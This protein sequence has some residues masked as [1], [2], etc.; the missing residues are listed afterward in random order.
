MIEKAMKAEQDYLAAR[1]AGQEVILD[2]SSFG[3][4]N[5]EDYFEAKKEYQMRHCGLVLHTPPMDTVIAEFIE[6]VKNQEPSVWIP[7]ADSVFVWHGDDVIDEDLCARLGV[8]IHQMPNFIGGNIISGPQ[9]FSMTV[10]MPSSIDITTEYMLE[11]MKTIMDKYIDGIVIDGNDFMLNG[12]KV[13][14]VMNL[15]TNGMYL[16]AT[17]VS[18]VDYTDYID[19]ICKKPAQKTPGFI[20]EAKLP[21]DVLQREVLEWLNCT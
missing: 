13:M 4:P 11:K 6:A 19:Q 16:F 1:L 9:D 12:R 10:A 18:Y 7:F 14:G 17:H 20:D 15:R 5:L 8:K 21:R 3:Y 2:L